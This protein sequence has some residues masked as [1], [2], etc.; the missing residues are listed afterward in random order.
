MSRDA[1]LTGRT[2][3]RLGFGKK[4]V[5]QVEEAG[6]SYDDTDPMDLYGRPYSCFRDA[7]LEDL[8]TLYTIRGVSLPLP[9]AEVTQ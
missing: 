5:L 7:T 6:R 8:Q 9:D 2:R 3:Y 4:L 1:R